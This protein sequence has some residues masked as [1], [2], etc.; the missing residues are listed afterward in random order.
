MEKFRAKV[1]V[2]LANTIFFGVAK[3][4]YDWIKIKR[5]AKA[6][7][8]ANPNSRYLHYSQSELAS[9]RTE[10][11]T[12]QYGQDYFLWHD[13]LAQKDSGVFV[14]IGANQP[15][16]NSN[17]LYLERA[18]WTGVAIDP[19]KRFQEPWNKMRETTL[20]CGA[21]ATQESDVAFIEI[22]QRQGWEHALSGFKEHIRQDD[23]TIYDYDEYLV[24]SKPLHLFIQD[25]ATVD[26][27]LIDVEGAEMQ[28]LKG[29]DFNLFS[30]SYILIENDDLVGDCDT[31]RVFLLDRGYKCVARISATD[32]L[33]IKDP[34]PAEL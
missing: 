6:F 3:R 12:S 18:G 26:L 27:I 24:K 8:L 15:I 31:I 21:V 33:Y 11:F 5:D 1:K 23:L 34:P 30:P 17:S 22:K 13:I 32:D 20:I 29:I 16:D 28:V 2:L 25:P 4:A 9:Q 10:G 14:D 7:R 19:L